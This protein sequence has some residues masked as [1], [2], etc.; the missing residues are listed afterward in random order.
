MRLTTFWD[1][2]P[3][4]IRK[5]NCSTNCI[6]PNSSDTFILNQLNYYGMKQQPAVFVA[7]I[8]R[9]RL[10]TYLNSEKLLKRNNKSWRIVVLFVRLLVIGVK[11]SKYKSKV[12]N[13][14]III[15]FILLIDSYY[16]NLWWT[17]DIASV[18]DGCAWLLC[19]LRGCPWSVEVV[20]ITWALLCSI[21][22]LLTAS[23]L[24]FHPVGHIRWS[25]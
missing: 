15:R 18:W 22:G 11:W 21:D 3:D 10:K 14:I 5:L 13:S 4:V 12:Y 24:M 20:R 8:K 17:Y 9:Y 25:W 23:V 2:T 16:C 19:Y 6:C 7:I 1:L